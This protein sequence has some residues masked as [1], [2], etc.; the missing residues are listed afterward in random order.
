MTSIRASVRHPRYRRASPILLALLSAALA[1]VCLIA[2]SGIALAGDSSPANADAVVASARLFLPIISHTDGSSDTGAQY[3]TVPVAESSPDGRP[4]ALHGDLNLALRGYSPTSGTLGLVNYGGDTDSNAP[5][6]A[7]I[8]SDRR[9]PGFTSA[10]RVYD[11]DW[12]CSADGCR[13]APISYPPVTL[14]GLQTRPGELLSIPFRGPEIYGGGYK[15]LVLYAE[16]ARITLVYTRNDHVKAGYTVH[17]EG[18]SVDS[19]LLALYRQAN[20]AGRSS[21]P[22]LQ[23]DQPLGMASG[24]EIRVAIRDRGSFLDPRSRKDWWQGY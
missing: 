4:A 17:L 14:L 7:G 11:W 10:H 8:F 18:I 21:L 13:G 5:Q 12:G 6:L 1:C 15:A 24:Y 2:P 19:H 22:A 16:P 20:A 3:E 9:L 23:N